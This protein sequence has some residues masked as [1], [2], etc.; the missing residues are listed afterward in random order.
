MNR[1]KWAEY[2]NIRLL[3]IECTQPYEWDARGATHIRVCMPVDAGHRREMLCRGFT[4]VDRM[5]DVSVN[6]ARSKLDFAALVRMEPVITSERR[7]EV[8]KIARQSFPTDSRFHLNCAPNQEVADVVLRGWVDALS[9]YYLCEHR[10]EAIGFLALTGEGEQRFVHLAAVLE[11]YRTSGAALS[12]YAAAAQ[13]CKTAGV[14]VLTGRISTSNPAVMNL[15]AFLGGS[16]S[17]P[18][19]IYHKEM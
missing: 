9:E 11:R 1:E 8:Y 16:F 12:L 3:N 13:N 19:D 14:R 7:D 17:N 18:T 4:Y 15:Y 2:P 6:L 10:G 5:L